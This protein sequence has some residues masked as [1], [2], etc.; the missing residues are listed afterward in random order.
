V[1]IANADPLWSKRRYVAGKRRRFDLL[2]IFNARVVILQVRM[3]PDVSDHRVSGMPQFPKVQATGRGW[4]G[5]AGT[6][7]L[8]IRVSCTFRL[9]HPREFQFGEQPQDFSLLRIY[10]LGHHES[11]THGIKIATGGAPSSIKLIPIGPI[12]SQYRYRSLCP[13]SQTCQRN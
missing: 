8:A 4:T 2:A 5:S 12:P 11:C 3:E 13:R 1:Q 6:R 7:S 10:R 9:S